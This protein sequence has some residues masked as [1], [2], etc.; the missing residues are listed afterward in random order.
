LANKVAVLVWNANLPNI[1]WRRGTLI[2]SKNGRYKPDA[3]LYNG[4]EYPAL[5]GTY[6]IRHYV[7]SKAVYVTVGNDLDAALAMLERLNATRAKEAA[8]KTLGIAPAPKPDE[9]AV[10]TIEEQKTAF[11]K[12]RTAGASKSN[13]ALYAVTVESFCQFVAK[14]GKTLPEEITG[15][16]VYGVYLRWKEIGRKQYTCANRYSTLRG[17]LHYMGINPKEIVDPVDHAKMK[18]KPKKIVQTYTDEEIKR[19]IAVSS[20]RHALLWECFQKFGFR[21]E[22]M[23]VLEWSNIDWVNKTAEVKFKTVQVPGREGTDWRSKDSEERAVPVEE[24]LLAKLAAWRQKNPK[25]RFIFGTRNDV[26]D[27]KFLVALKSDWRKAGLNCGQCLGCVAKRKQCSRAYIHKF[28]A[29]YLTRMFRFCDNPRDVMALAG[30]SSIETSLKYLQPSAQ[31]S[32]QRA[33]NAAW[34]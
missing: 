30:H 20:E 28:R 22:E 14:A 5:Q 34:A 26:P 27:I 24:K 4:V 25:T 15:D 11:L 29:T 18:F 31:P 3:M 9:K 6:Q 16:D 33:V 8:E 7:G 32:L 1:G 13:T 12:K 10:K 19:L 23:A 2:K 21:D 17:F